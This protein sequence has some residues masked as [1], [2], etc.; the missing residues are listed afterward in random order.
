[1]VVAIVVVVFVSRVSDEA[2]GCTFISPSTGSP[3]IGVVVV[4]VLVIVFRR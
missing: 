3:G 4:V 1:M 2:A